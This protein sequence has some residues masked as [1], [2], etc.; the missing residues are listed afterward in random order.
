MVTSQRWRGVERGLVDW[1]KLDELVGIDLEVHDPGRAVVSLEAERLVDAQCGVKVDRFLQ[2][3]NPV[4]VVGQ[5]GNHREPPVGY[6]SIRRYA[7]LFMI[8]PSGSPPPANSK[9][10]TTFCGSRA[11]SART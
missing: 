7:R 1:E 2:I 10:C 9:M 5:L 3:P 11:N 4:G 6:S 8:R